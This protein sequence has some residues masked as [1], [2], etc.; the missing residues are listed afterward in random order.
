MQR[1]G[2]DAP[3]LLFAAAQRLEAIDRGLAR[4]TYRDAFVAAFYAGRLAGDTGLPEIAA[5]VRLAAPSAHPPSPTDELLDAAALLVDAGYAQGAPQVK[6]ALVAFR[7]APLSRDAELH[8]LVLASR[9]ALWV[10][11]DQG[12]DALSE[13]ILALARESGTYALQ[14]MAAALRVAWDLFAGDLG[15]GSAHVVE[16][17][18]VLEAVG[19]ER[20]PTARLALAAFRGRDA[21]FAQLDEANT[22]DAL[23]RG[24]GQW[25]AIRHWTS[26]VLGNGLGRYQEALDGAQQ[27]AAYPPELNMSNWA[28]SELVEAATHCGQ[29]EAAAGALERL[30]EMARACG[31]DWILGVEAR[32]RAL[33]AEPDSADQLHR[34]AIEHL[35][36]TKLRTELARAH[37]LYGEWLRRQGRR[38]DAREQLHAA[39]ELFSSIGME[40]FAARAAKELLATGERLR[41]RTV[42]TRDQLTAQE[43]HIAQLAC[44]G[45]SNPEIGAR[46]FLSPRT[47]EWHLRNVFNKL[48]IR[49]RRELADALP[50]SDSALVSA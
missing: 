40:A 25:L 45:L 34:L 47:I 9:M 49:S 17:D 36:R 31:T 23:A 2:S 13:R 14:P 42:E 19:G 30:S 24:E 22:R 39:H 1:R 12:W 33:V 21:E 27:G 28:L 3:P 43:R 29:P 18:T 5:A 20:S 35:G 11:D 32:A 46:L 50:S 6:R 44:D 16:Q 37:L 10:W 48:G 41:K 15:V 38:V 7:A 8:W 4:E 26:A